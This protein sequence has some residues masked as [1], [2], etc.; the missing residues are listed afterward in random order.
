MGAG[1]DRRV[2]ID[3]DAAL[4]AAT[5]TNYKR[6]RFDASSAG[7]PSHAYADVH[8]E[9]VDDEWVDLDVPVTAA[10]RNAV[11]AMGALS[12]KY[13]SGGNFGGLGD[14]IRGIMRC[15]WGDDVADHIMSVITLNGTDEEGGFMAALDLLE[16]YATD[17]GVGA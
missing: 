15:Q 3:I 2:G 13:R 14:A 16:D 11:I 17:H 12:L 4:K 6:F 10:D 7:T 9:L 8:A 5:F 1:V